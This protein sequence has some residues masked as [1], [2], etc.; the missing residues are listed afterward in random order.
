M[1]NYLIFYYFMDYERTGDTG[2]MDGCVA[3]LI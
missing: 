3:D 1:L 2:K